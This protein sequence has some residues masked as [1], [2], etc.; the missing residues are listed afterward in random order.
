MT[1]SIAARYTYTQDQLASKI[2]ST[3]NRIYIA[4]LQSLISLDY[5]IDTPDKAKVLMRL[6]S[7]HC[8]SSL[9]TSFDTFEFV[10][11]EA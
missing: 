5:I 3:C 6:H 2:N 7:V 8:H 11:K 10:T 4:L 9:M 1:F